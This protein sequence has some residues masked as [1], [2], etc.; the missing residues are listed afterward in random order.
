MLAAALAAGPLG[1]SRPSGPG[2]SLL[3]AIGR[4]VVFQETAILNAADGAPYDSFG[5]RVAIDGGT[6]AIAGKAPWSLGQV[7]VFERDPAA[8]GGWAQVQQL[9]PADPDGASTFGFSL[10]V[11]GD[12]MAIGTG[13][14]GAEYLGRLYLFER[15][16]DGQWVERQQIASPGGVLGDM[17]GD[18]LDLDGGSLIVGAQSRDGE[19][20]PRAGALFL[21]ERAAGG[22]WLL[23][24]EQQGDRPE[25]YLGWEVALDGDTALAAEYDSDLIHVLERDGGGP[26]AWG[27]VALLEPGY[28]D[29]EFANVMAV[30]LREDTAV[31]GLV[32]SDQR[33]LRMGVFVFERDPAD[34]WAWREVQYLDWRD[35]TPLHY[36]YAFGRV[37]ALDGDFLLVGAPEWSGEGRLNQGAALL[38]QRWPGAPFRHVATW[39]ASDGA[40][41]SWFGSDV[42]LDGGVAIVGAPQ[43]ATLRIGYAYVFERP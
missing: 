5:Y 14:A 33:D 22:E 29:S 20:G 12:W 16:G 39:L 9:T 32:E 13:Q 23:V 37:L 2:R 10:D 27:E 24:R 7:H 18:S 40:Q 35:Y 38:F 4:P 15:Q 1:A 30:R 41:F 8:A 17:F 11:S 28:P 36:P 6:I 25:Q 43:S 34:P 42:D 21:F 31:V 3:P 19:A 26:G